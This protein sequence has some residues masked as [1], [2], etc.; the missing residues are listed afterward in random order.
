MVLFNVNVAT[1][2]RIVELVRG[3]V[4]FTQTVTVPVASF[5]TCTVIVVFTPTK[6]SI[7]VTLIG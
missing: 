6:T 3:P 5:G 2:S 7:A 1:P 4:P